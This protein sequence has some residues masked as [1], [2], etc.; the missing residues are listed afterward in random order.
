[1]KKIH[2]DNHGREF[3]KESCFVGGKMKIRRVYVIDGIPTDEFYENNATDLDFYV[4]RDYA[5][6]DS[7]K[8]SAKSF[9]EQVNKK[10]DG[11]GNENWVDLPF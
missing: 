11:A 5:L 10:P 3:I 7:K 1:M 4:N 6:M 2:K 9:Q 8:N